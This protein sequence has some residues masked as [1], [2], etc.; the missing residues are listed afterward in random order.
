MEKSEYYGPMAAR[1]RD[2]DLSRQL[3]AQLEW[4]ELHLNNQASLA[5]SDETDP[6]TSDWWASATVRVLPDEDEAD[7][8][9]PWYKAEGTAL[10]TKR[11]DEESSDITIFEATGLTIDLQHVEDV[12]DALDARSEDYAKF[13]PLFGGRDQFGFVTLQDDLEDLRGS[14]SRS[15]ALTSSF[16]QPVGIR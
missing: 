10:S 5:G 11:L 1:R 9:Q 13:I 7:G 2:P 3:L 4:V 12:H 6:G 8:I 16:T 14:K 15:P